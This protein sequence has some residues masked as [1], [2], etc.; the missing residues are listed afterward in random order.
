MTYRF[1][2]C[3]ALVS[4]FL[5]LATGCGGSGPLT[6]KKTKII[7]PWCAAN[8]RV[9][10]GDRVVGKVAWGENKYKDFFVDDA[11]KEHDPDKIADQ[12][13]TYLERTGDAKKI[14][15]AFSKGDYPVMRVVSINP[16]IVILETK[17]DVNLPKQ[18]GNSPGRWY[19][20]AQVSTRGEPGYQKDLQWFSPDLKQKPTKLVFSLGGIGEIPL[21]KGALKLT[22]IG[23]RC[24][25][26]RE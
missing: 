25:T 10:I 20:V 21:G 2:P 16:L 22:R 17:Q 1:R 5:C 7:G 26:E 14:K 12:V 9:Q 11:G 6:I 18:L 8:Q 19:W 13:W 23:E 24:T 3:I 15:E 4:A